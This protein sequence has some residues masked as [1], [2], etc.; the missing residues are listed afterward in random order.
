MYLS[1][2]LNDKENIVTSLI[3]LICHQRAQLHFGPFHHCTTALLV[4]CEK[5]KAV[6]GHGR[7]GRPSY[8]R[9][10]LLV[11][12]EGAGRRQGHKCSGRVVQRDIWKVILVY[13]MCVFALG[14]YIELKVHLLMVFRRQSMMALLWVLDSLPSN[15]NVFEYYGEDWSKGSNVGNN[16]YIYFFVFSYVKFYYL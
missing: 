2:P 16:I 13:P 1:Q 4:D 11:Q 3:K 15:W 9:K 5:D 8:L 12:T 10:D 6:L 14:L 7:V